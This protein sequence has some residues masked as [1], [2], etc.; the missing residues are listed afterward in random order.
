MYWD[1]AKEACAKLGKG[2]RLPTD[3]EIKLLYVNRKKVN[4]FSY[5]NYLSSTKEHYL[6]FR[7]GKRGV[8]SPNVEFVSDKPPIV[9]AVK[10][11]YSRGK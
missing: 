4:N 3:T 5:G 1:D 2:W 10:Y 6:D 9:R 11:Y 7:N 8:L